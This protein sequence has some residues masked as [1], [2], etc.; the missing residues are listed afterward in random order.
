MNTMSQQMV[1]RILKRML[2]NGPLTGIPK[3]PGDQ[4]LLA[5]LAAARLD[6]GG[7]YTE[8][9]VNE[10]LREWL[11]TFV[12][13][14]GIDHV[15]LRRMIVDAR[16][17]VRTKSGSCYRVNEAKLDELRG[18]DEVEPAQVLIAVR[19]ERAARKARVSR[20]A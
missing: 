3:R 9:E 17:L 6:A 15:T 2:A 8:R 12:E 10:R 11:A 16:L 20:E 18:L 19:Q 7:E 5:R 4:E 1:D 13:P 14:Y